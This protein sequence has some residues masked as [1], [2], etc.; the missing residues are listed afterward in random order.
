[1]NTFNNGA[2]SQTYE[3]LLAE[4][5]LMQNQLL[6]SNQQTNE[7][8]QQNALLRAN[9]SSD[10]VRLANSSSFPSANNGIVAQIGNGTGTSGSQTNATPN[11][12][13]NT[14]A[15]GMNSTEPTNRCFCI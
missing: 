9:L 6:D 7:L 2:S 14:A 3:T 11:R 13:T 5:R 15:Q 12:G 8:R 10:G 1:M 4:L